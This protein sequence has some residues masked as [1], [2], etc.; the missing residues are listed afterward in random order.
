M[1]SKTAARLPKREPAKNPLLARW[2]T[3]FHL[4][5]F[6]KIEP[7]HFKPALEAAFRAHLAEIKAISANPAKPTFANTIAALEKSGS[8]LDRAASVFFN[9]ESA[10]STPELQA[11]AR[12]M[13]PRFAKHETQISL[14]QKLFRRIDDLY[15]RR[16]K[17]D[18]TDEQKRVLERHHLSFVRAGAKLSS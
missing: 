7:R 13:S 8:D 3:T 2:N 15:Q 11:I 10:N 1:K 16:D 14:D 6:D 4:P 12:E 9:M 18:L 17:L 5:P